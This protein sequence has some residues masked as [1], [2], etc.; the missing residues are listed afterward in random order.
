MRRFKSILYFADGM[1]VSGAALERAVDLA[2]RNQA[3][4]TLIDVIEAQ[5]SPP[6]IEQQ[7]GLD[8]NG[9]LQ[10]R[11]RDDLERLIA[12][13]EERDKLVPTRVISG[14]PFVE[15]IRAVLQ[16]GYDLVVK[17]ARP[18]QGLSG[19]LLGSTDMHLLRK[20]PCPMW[21][22][23]QTAYT[24]YRQVLAAVDPVEPTRAGCAR[25]VMD[26]ATSLAEQ[27]GAKP[28]VVHAWRMYGESILS[29]GRA[30]LTQSDLEQLV[31]QTRF[32]HEE[33]LDLLLSAYDMNR[34]SPGVHLIKGEPAP[35][36][37]AVAE[38]TDADLIVMGTVGRTGIPGFFIGNTAEE[39]LQTA[40]ASILA[41]KPEGFVSPVTAN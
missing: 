15:V 19:R 28:S 8:L 21:I 26:L 20:C 38:R 35:S 25:L 4:L 18:P 29:E 1:T 10:E 34:E 3:R 5:D 32:H 12:P 39:V 24:P 40:A 37:R 14:T 17:P 13:F 6:G 33:S 9:L 27:E 7:F 16:N 31:D 30:R 41:V 2:R 22:E 23:R 11:R 36:I